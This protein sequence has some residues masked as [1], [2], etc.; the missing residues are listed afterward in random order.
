MGLQGKFLP[1]AKEIFNL[2]LFPSNDVLI[3]L[4]LVVSNIALNSSN[5]C[6]NHQRA[7]LY[8]LMFL[9]PS[10]DWRPSGPSASK[11]H[12]YLSLTPSRTNTPRLGFC[13]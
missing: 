12:S 5:Y 13:T 3:L 6:C 7:V 11:M 9:T 8:T 10:L 2:F 4:N 1:L